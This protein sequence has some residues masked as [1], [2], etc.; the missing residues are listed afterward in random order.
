MSLRLLLGSIG[1]DGSASAGTGLRD[2]LLA[3]ADPAGRWPEGCLLR[4]A[5]PNLTDDGNGFGRFCGLAR[6]V[7]GRLNINHLFLSS[8]L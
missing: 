4:R 1:S 7:R 8:L 5:G 2:R 6:R 3:P